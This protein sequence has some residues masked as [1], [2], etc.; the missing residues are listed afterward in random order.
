MA[1]LDNLFNNYLRVLCVRFLRSVGFRP[2]QSAASPNADNH[3]DL[4]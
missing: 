1:V 4:N 3:C 2:L